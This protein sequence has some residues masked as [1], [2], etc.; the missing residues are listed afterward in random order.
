MNRLLLMAKIR[1]NEK[2]VDDLCRVCAFSRTTFYRKIRGMTEFTQREI[3]AS[4]RL[5]NLDLDTMD[6]IFLR[7]EA[8]GC[9]E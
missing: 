4:K 1:E 3:A 8:W 2:T 9:D 6:R 7:G 5:L